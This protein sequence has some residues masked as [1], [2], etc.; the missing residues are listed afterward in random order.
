MELEKPNAYPLKADTAVLPRSKT[1]ETASVRSATFS[2][3]LQTW[4]QPQ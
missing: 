2:E 3:F 4:K 1:E